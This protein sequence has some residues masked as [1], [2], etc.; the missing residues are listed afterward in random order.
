MAERFNGVDNCT[1]CTGKLIL[2]V[3]RS[4]QMILQ[5]DHR[6]GNMIIGKLVTIP[7]QFG[8]LVAWKPDKLRSSVSLMT[9]EHKETWMKGAYKVPICIYFPPLSF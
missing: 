6:R 7:I 2:P 3:D 1:F 8:N 9:A 5:N 4:L